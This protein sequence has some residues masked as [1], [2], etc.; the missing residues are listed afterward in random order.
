MPPVPA[1][2]VR[3]ALLAPLLV[4]FLCLTVDPAALGETALLGDR[5]EAPT[6]VELAAGPGMCSDKY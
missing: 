2:V 1:D 4:V 6:L 5:L 3:P